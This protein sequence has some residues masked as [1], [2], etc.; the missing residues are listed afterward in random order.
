[1]SLGHSDALTA[2]TSPTSAQG[3]R[4]SVA[5]M[6]STPRVRTCRFVMAVHPCGGV[7]HRLCAADDRFFV[8]RQSPHLQGRANGLS[9]LSRWPALTREMMTTP[10]ENAATPGALEE[11]RQRY[12]SDCHE[13][14]PF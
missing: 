9:D 14:C 10:M 5:I 12:Q 3:A 1:M 8:V 4:D 11:N 6:R 13:T 2:P 7:R